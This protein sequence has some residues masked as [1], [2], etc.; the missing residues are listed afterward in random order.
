MMDINKVIQVIQ[1]A[2]E[3]NLETIILMLIVV[4]SLYLINILFGTI[5]GTITEEFIPKKFFFG[6]FK[7]LVAD[8]GIFSFCYTL[9]LFS[10]TL[11]QT[12]DIS[13]S[14][15]F[16]T[17]IEVFTILVV[18]GI[19]LAKDIVEKIK[20]MKTLKYISYDDVQVQQNPQREE[21]IG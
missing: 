4:S 10:L 16:I 2:V 17:T 5:V 8:V 9:N 6:I 20:S 21:G 15:D 13:I 19:D 14:A 18:W 11:Q 12:K 7:G 3:E 1:S